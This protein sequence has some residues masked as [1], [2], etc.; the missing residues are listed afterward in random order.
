[1][2]TNNLSRLA[3]LLLTII[4][5]CTMQDDA[6]L[7]QT[8]SQSIAVI[9]STQE[10]PGTKSALSGIETHWVASTDQ[11]GIFS[12]QAKP[13][14]GGTAPTNNA[15]FT[16]K[17]SAKSSAFTGTMYWG[18]AS[19]AHSFYAYYP[20]NSGYSGSQTVVPISLSPS[21]GQT[22]AG[23]SDHIGS[24]DFMVATPLTVAY[25]G[26][27]NLTF[28][29]VFSMIEFQIKGSGSLK[30][31]TLIGVS[32]LAFGSGT[33]DLTQTPGANAYTITKSSTS[34]SA[35]VSLATPVALSSETAVSIYMMVLPGTQTSNMTISLKIGDT[36]KEMSKAQPTGGFIRGKK[37]V[38]AL[39]T[40]T[41]WTN[42]V[43]T[44]PRD[45]NIYPYITIGTQ[46][47]MTKNLAYLPSVSPAATGSSSGTYYYVYG[48]Q[49]TSV[50]EAKAEPNYTALG[51][52]YNWTAA[53]NRAASSDSNPSG[54]QGVCPSG[55][56]LPSDAEW[57][58]LTTYLG[59]ESVAGGKMKETG[60]THWTEPN[61]GA[62]NASGF[63]ARSGG[64]RYY[65][66]QFFSIGYYGDWWTT[67]EDADRAWRR[68]LLYNSGGVTRD[69]YDKEGGF[70]V[71]CLRD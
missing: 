16:A 59:G 67:Q 7:D 52:L 1:M 64:Y 10:E 35:S 65:N 24:L 63:T 70:S 17:S 31:V 44:D 38:V 47:W 11:I 9:A 30:Q 41:G 61:T 42:G 2:K 14:E 57:T 34:N 21:Q 36:W 25:N 56:H 8:L 5:A 19:T 6:G 50:A 3:V 60:T 18:S 20:R 51:V 69:R 48:Y 55:W 15:A 49:G 37:Y 45:G 46:V 53:M 58:Q 71:R 26:A 12:P 22:Q 28:H 29:H 40:A 13:T 43:F 23:N 68:R 33:I 27:V 32:P 39:N 66:G 54:V 4:N 62:T